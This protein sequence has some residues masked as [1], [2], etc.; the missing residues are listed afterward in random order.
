MAP[1]TVD[2]EREALEAKSS[3]KPFHERREGNSSR[4]ASHD[5]A[6]VASLRSEGGVAGLAKPQMSAKEVYLT[7]GMYGLLIGGALWASLNLIHWLWMRW[8]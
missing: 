8:T 7:L 1:L 3:A 6:A 5:V 2:A 4:K